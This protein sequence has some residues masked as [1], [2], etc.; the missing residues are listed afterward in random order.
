MYHLTTARGLGS[1]ARSVSENSDTKFD[2]AVQDAIKTLQA[3]AP[4]T[5]NTF[6]MNTWL[7]QESNLF[8]IKPV[9]SYKIYFTCTTLLALLNYGIRFMSQPS[10]KWDVFLRHPSQTCHSLSDATS[11]IV[12]MTGIELNAVVIITA[13]KLQARV[14]A[15]PSH[16]FYWSFR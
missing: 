15:M 8:R 10:V 6:A 5:R 1:G 12:D 14:I 4:P 2:F 9:I 13:G 3:K 11:D 7:Q 16:S